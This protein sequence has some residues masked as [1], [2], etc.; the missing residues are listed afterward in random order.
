MRYSGSG[1]TCAVCPVIRYT[2]AM[3]IDQRI[4]TNVHELLWQK[5]MRQEP[6]MREMGLSRSSLA[7]KL[8]GEVAWMARD[9]DAAA[10]VLDVDPGQLFLVAGAGFEPAT[11]G[12]RARQDREAL[13]L[14]A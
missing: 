7:R 10:R 14:A 3:T 1:I 5:R 12:S 2:G 11:S 13:G 8:R 6:L 9:I 4:G